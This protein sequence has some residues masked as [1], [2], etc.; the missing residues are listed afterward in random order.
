MAPD[1]IPDGLSAA[2]TYAALVALRA[3][4][5]AQID[6]AKAAALAAVNGLSKATYPTA[7]GV[8][9]VS[10]PPD[11]ISLDDRAFL[12]LVEEHYPDEVVVTRSVRSSFKAA[13]LED[14]VVVGGQVMH[15][16]TGEVIDFARVVPGGSPRLSYPASLE[17]RDAKALA[18]MLFEERAAT[19][20]SGLRE[21][22]A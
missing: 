4:L 5:D 11:A 9:N 10:T 8:V 7:Y 6:K 12:A 14:L 15:K 2:E 13:F 18:T 21:V 20:V 17:Q 3:G 22:T 19:L 16:T 1:P